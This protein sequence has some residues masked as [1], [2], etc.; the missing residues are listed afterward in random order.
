MTCKSTTPFLINNFF[1]L[2]YFFRNLQVIKT[3]IKCHIAAQELDFQKDSTEQMLQKDLSKLLVE[4]VTEEFAAVKKLSHLL[5]PSFIIE[6]SNFC[7]F[8][9]YK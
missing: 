2:V 8:F 1:D 4:M 7:A 3:I 5:T 6:R 9:M